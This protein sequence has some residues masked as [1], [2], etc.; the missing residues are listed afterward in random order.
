M[1]R[2]GRA[3]RSPEQKKMDFLFELD[4]LCDR[5][6]N[7]YYKEYLNYCKIKGY[8]LDENEQPIRNY[9]DEILNGLIGVLGNTSLIMDWTRSYDM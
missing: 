3:H 9:N 7:R 8:E 1:A 2:I 5:V 4:Q 6:Y